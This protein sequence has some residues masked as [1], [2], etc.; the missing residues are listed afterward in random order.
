V[1]GKVPLKITNNVEVDPW[2]SNRIRGKIDITM[3]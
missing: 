1:I 2:G 3:A